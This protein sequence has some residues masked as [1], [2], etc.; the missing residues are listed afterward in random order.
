[1]ND[2]EIYRT[3]DD[4]AKIKVYLEQLAERLHDKWMDNALR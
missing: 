4:S 1:M 2:F 3:K